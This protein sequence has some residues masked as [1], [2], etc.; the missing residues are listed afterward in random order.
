[1]SRSKWKGPYIKP[2]HIKTKDQIKK[3]HTHLVAS[4]NSEVT[5]H[6]IGLTF[7][8]YNGNKHIKLNVTKDMIGHKFGE[9]SQTRAIFQFK[10]KTKKK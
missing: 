1:M 8:I 2:Q 9:F 6:F 3:Q 5:S 10:K 7:N 4:R